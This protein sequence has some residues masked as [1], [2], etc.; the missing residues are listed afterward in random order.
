MAKPV[1]GPK[2]GQPTFKCNIGS[3]S[4]HRAPRSAST[5]SQGSCEWFKHDCEFFLVKLEQILQ[6]KVGC[7]NFGPGQDLAIYPTSA[8]P[9]LR[10]TG[11][12]G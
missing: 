7:L 6:L 10:W 12:G 11:G 2:F 8:Q 4:I 9:E 1:T 3:G 5:H